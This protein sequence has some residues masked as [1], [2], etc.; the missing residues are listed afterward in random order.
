MSMADGTWPLKGGFSAAKRE[1]TGWRGDK[2]KPAAASPWKH[3]AP[4]K[5]PRRRMSRRVKLAL[6]TGG[7]AA[8]VL[9]YVIYVTLRPPI[10]P[11]L[12]AIVEQYE[13]PTIPPNAWAG[14]DKLRLLSLDQFR[15]I[16][17]LDVTEPEDTQTIRVTLADDPANVVIGLAKRVQATP[18][19]GPNGRV[20]L[21]YVSAHGVVDEEAKPCLLLE[22]SHPFRSDTWL[23]V[24]DLVTALDAAASDSRWPKGTSKWCCSSTPTGSTSI[25]RSVNSAA[26]SGKPGA[27]VA[28][29]GA[30]NVTI[31]TAASPG[32]LGWACAELRERL[33]AILS[34]KDSAGA[35]RSAR[36]DTLTQDRISVR[37]CTSTSR[38]IGIL[39]CRQSLGV[40]NAAPLARSAAERQQ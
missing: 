9:S 33:L 40:A 5:G 39:G 16:R 15:S 26:T 35:R 7:L 30:K 37:A 28:V 13:S 4:S 12:V 19:G 8:M 6:W 2:A 10:V 14:A 18:G 25:S 1:H 23:K 20:V 36:V 3:S 31:I 21:L 38:P 22:K 27:D 32:E 24:N 29:G 11:L 17:P 34:A